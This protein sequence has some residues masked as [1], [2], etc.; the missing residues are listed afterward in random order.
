MANHDRPLGGT[1]GGV[2]H[3][4]RCAR[5]PVQRLGR[6]LVCGKQLIGRL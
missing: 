5:L 3:L 2:V 6:V 4:S 1:D